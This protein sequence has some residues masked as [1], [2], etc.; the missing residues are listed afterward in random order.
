[1]KLRLT[2]SYGLND[3]GFAAIGLGVVAFIVALIFALGGLCWHA[4]HVDCLRL[5]EQT[6]YPTRMVG[7]MWGGGCYVLVDNRWIPDTRYR[8]V[9]VG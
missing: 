4:D 8:M 6:G 9:D 7:T 2:D 3:W 5:H 1:M